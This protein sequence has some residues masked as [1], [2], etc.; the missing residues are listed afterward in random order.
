MIHENKL[1]DNAF[2]KS[3]GIE[4]LTATGVLMKKGISTE[5]L[6]EMATKLFQSTIEDVNKKD[7]DDDH[8]ILLHLVLTYHMFTHAINVF[9]DWIRIGAE[10]HHMKP[11][12]YA[13]I[14]Y[15]L[16]DWLD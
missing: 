11:D 7:I 6:E 14:I 2:K 10:E 8:K 5:D 9:N 13:K 15:S 3:T 12:K 16:Q 4:I 1:V